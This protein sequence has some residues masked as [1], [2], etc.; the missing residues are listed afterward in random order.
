M[1]LGEVLEK[2]RWATRMTEREL[3]VAIGISYSTL[4]RI[5]HGKTMDGETLSRILVWLLSEEAQREPAD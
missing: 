3:A 2:Y 4:N 1:K 5:E